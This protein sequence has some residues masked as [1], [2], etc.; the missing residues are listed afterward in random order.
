MILSEREIFWGLLCVSVL[1]C[2][3]SACAPGA[4]V[5]PLEAPSGQYSGGVYLL[6]DPAESVEIFVKG[7]PQDEVRDAGAE[8]HVTHQFQR[9]QNGQLVSLEPYVFRYRVAE[10][11]N[12]LVVI[13]KSQA[14]GGDGYLIYRLYVGDEL[15]AIKRVEIVKF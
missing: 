1:C 9:H 15:A 14:G 13:N 3:L 5:A 11:S 4:A 12:P 6:D 8:I 10:D 2:A 7:F